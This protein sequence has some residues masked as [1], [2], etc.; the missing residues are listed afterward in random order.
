MEGYTKY[1]SRSQI[2]YGGVVLYIKSSLK[3]S[4]CYELTQAHECFDSLYVKIDPSNLHDEKSGNRRPLF[5]GTYYRHCKTS[6][7]IPYISRLDC[8]L[9][10]RFL[11]KSDVIITGDFN[12]CLMKSTSNNDSL[13]LLNTIISN[14]FEIMIFKPTRIQYHKDSL[15]IKSA[16]LI[17]QIITNLF[18]H[19]CKSGNLSYP[20]SDHYANFLVVESYMKEATPNVGKKIRLNK[21][22]DENK[23]AEDFKRYDWNR[24]VYLEADLDIAVQNLSDVLQQLCDQHA[25]L[26]TPS[27]RM[28]KHMNKPW[29][30]NELLALTKNKNRAYNKKTSTPTAINKLIYDR[31]NSQ[32]TAMKRRNKKRY[33]KEYFTRF[34]H[35]SKKLWDGINIALEQTKH[36]KAL[37]TVIYDVDGVTPIEGDKKNRRCICQVFQ[38]CTGQNEK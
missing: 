15:Q 14:N 30:D 13:F 5:I 4:Y 38:I 24:L 10:H 35:N 1:Y 28:K 37:P 22:I 8:D 36:K 20:D 16:T 27:N 23:L 34:K 26:T 18:S 17:D 12:I 7:I 19:N 9:K 31:L 25:P 6:G 33:F 21:N 2:K 11:Q 29:I 3:A 32:V